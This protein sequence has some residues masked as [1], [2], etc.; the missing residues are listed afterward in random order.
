MRTVKEL[1]AD[2]LHPY[3]VRDRGLIPRSPGARKLQTPT[4]GKFFEE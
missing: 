3:E 1:L 2:K 4:Q